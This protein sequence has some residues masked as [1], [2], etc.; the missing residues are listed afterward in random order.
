[1][2]KKTVI[3]KTLKKIIPIA[4]TGEKDGEHFQGALMQQE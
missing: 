1:L 2:I 3:K 4:V